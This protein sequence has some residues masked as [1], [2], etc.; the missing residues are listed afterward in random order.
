M[1]LSQRRGGA[2]KSLKDSARI[3]DKQ[4]FSLC[5]APPRRCESIP[6]FEA[7]TTPESLTNAD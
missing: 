5:A 1:I 4:F 2:A 7:T 3:S 6:V